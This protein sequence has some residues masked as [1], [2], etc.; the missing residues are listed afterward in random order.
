MPNVDW[1][2]LIVGVLLGMWGLP[3][4]FSL[5]SGRRKTQTA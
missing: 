2:W 4:L 3:L 1:T 5:I